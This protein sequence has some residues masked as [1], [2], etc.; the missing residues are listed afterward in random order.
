[1]TG[2][3]RGG[4]T[5]DLEALSEKLQA[6]GGVE[7]APRRVTP[8]RFSPVVTSKTGAHYQVDARGTARR[9]DKDRTLSGKARR[10]ARR[11]QR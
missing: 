7:T 11:Q 2:G 5:A 8:P 6:R 4:K 3:R 10:H 1:M 9:V